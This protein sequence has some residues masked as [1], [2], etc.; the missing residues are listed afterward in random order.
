MDPSRIE[1][2]LYCRQF[3]TTLSYQ[4][5]IVNKLISVLEQHTVF[6]KEIEKYGCCLLLQSFDRLLLCSL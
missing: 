2:G 6:I 4:R 3:I 1:K 5:M